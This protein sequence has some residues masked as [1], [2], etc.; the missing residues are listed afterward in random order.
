[1]NTHTQTGSGKADAADHK[2]FANAYQIVK[3]ER[4]TEVSGT[5]PDGRCTGT[6]DRCGT[7]ILNVYVFSDAAR[8][9]YMHV[10]IDCAGK[11]GVPVT[12][13]KKARGY[14]R[15]CARE[16]DR[17]ARAA[18]AAERKAKEDQARAARLAENAALV[19]DLE[20]LK[21]N[22]N[23]TDWERDQ[24][25][26]MVG[27]VANYGGEWA[28][29]DSTDDGPFADKNE[30][31]RATLTCIRERLA[32]CETSRPQVEAMTGKGKPAGF[33]R[34]LRGYRKA[35]VLNGQYGTTYISFMADDQGNA[36]VHKGSN[37]IAMGEVI[38]ATWSVDGTDT[39]DGL[40]AT[41][42]KR[43]RKRADKPAPEAT[44]LEP[45]SGK[46]WCRGFSRVD[47]EGLAEAF[48]VSVDDVQPLVTDE[49]FYRV[50][51]REILLC[52]FDEYPGV[53]W[54]KL[55]VQALYGRGLVMWEAL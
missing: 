25:A 50:D 23:A 4:G 19:D 29:P 31:R 47:A 28:D 2:W 3:S 22:P 37:L 34:V 33:R 20:T 45:C 41:V 55:P 26:L 14:W 52:A 5:G 10:G 27:L 51:G 39:R 32:L 11:M 53:K 43:P 17:A 13:L 7:A 6:C 9:S 35:V 54:R 15:E 8:S 12:E 42:L 18:T 21:G 40:T 44:D 46:P 16:A 38:E 1:M 36:Y 49:R 48:K 24:L 30:W